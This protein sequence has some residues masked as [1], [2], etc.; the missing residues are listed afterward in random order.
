MGMASWS[1]VLR[2]PMTNLN[3]MLPYPSAEEQQ[4]IANY[5]DS[6]VALIDI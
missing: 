4:A 2:I 6:K 5:L 3:T 1:T